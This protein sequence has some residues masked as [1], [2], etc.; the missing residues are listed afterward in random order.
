MEL[1]TPREIAEFTLEQDDDSMT[2]C[3]RNAYSAIRDALK[4]EADRL[5]PYNR[6]PVTDEEKY[7]YHRASEAASIRDAINAALSK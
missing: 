4:E 7:L 6:Q 5:W 3:V 2:A 1:K